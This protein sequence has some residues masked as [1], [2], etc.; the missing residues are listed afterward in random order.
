MGVE[1]VD[2]GGPA[3][4]PPILIHDFDIKL[5]VFSK[6]ERRGKQK[7]GDAGIDIIGSDCALFMMGTKSSVE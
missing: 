2:A 6:R 5:K 1:V 7:E 4:D 3:A